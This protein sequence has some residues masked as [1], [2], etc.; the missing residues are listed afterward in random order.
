MNCFFELH[1]IFWTVRNCL[2]FPKNSGKKFLR[3]NTLVKTRLSTGHIMVTH[4]ILN[5]LFICKH[6]KFL[7]FFLYV[8]QDLEKMFKIN[9]N[10]IPAPPNGS[11]RIQYAV[12]GRV[13]F[14]LCKICYFTCEI[15]PY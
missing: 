7:S 13:N 5:I 14:L 11:I 10:P 12:G 3:F 15:D 2:I 4:L 9:F 6:F 8:S 1:K